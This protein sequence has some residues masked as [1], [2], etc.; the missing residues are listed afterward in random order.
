MSTFLFWNVDLRGADVIDTRR[1]G[2]LVAALIRRYTPDVICLLECGLPAERLL[3][4]VGVD[5]DGYAVV[6]S[7]DRFRLLVR[8]NPRFVTRLALVPASDRMDAW[9]L[10]LPLQHELLIAVVHGLDRRNNPASRR[11]L[12]MQQLGARI[13]RAEAESGHER[14]VLF[15]DFNANPFE[16]AVFGTVGLHAVASRRVASGRSREVLGTASKFFYNPMWGL[17]GDARDGDRSIET[18]GGTYFYTNADPHDLY[19]HMLDQVVVRPDVVPMFDHDGLRI[20]TSLGAD[21][22]VTDSGVP[23]RRTASDHLPVVFRID[24]RLTTLETR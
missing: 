8:F 1:V 19:W 11:E 6:E 20:V 9:R 22:F 12:F 10:S 16:P 23:D 21:S 4:S 14:T 5:G 2:D 17:L 15:G 24:H 3:N 13:A 7:H 18:P